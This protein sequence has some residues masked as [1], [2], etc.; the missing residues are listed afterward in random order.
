MARRYFGTDGIRG[1]VGQAP[2]TPDFVL[3]LGWAAG[4]VL[5][6]RYSGPKLILIGK[7]TR[8]S[9]YMFESAL[10]AGLINGGVDVG[11]LGPMPTPAIAYLTRTFQAQAGIVISAS[12]NPYHD[13]GIKFFSGQGTKLPDDIE[14]NIEAQLDQPMVTADNLGK[15]RRIN[16]AQGRYIEFCKGTMP[17]GFSLQGLKI[18]LDCANGA[19]YHVAP[20]VFRELGATVTTIGTQPDGMN[21]NDECGSTAPAALQAKVLETEADLGIAFDGDGDRVVFVDHKGEVVDGD[22]LLY[23]IASYR[24]EYGSGCNGVVGTL[25]SNLGFELALQS[26][27]IP[28]VRAKVGDRYVIEAM[29]NNDWLLGGESSGHIICSDVTTTGD[30]VISALQVLLALVSSGTALHDAKQGMRKTPQFT[31]NVRISQPV[32]LDNAPAIRSAVQET[33]AHLNGRGRVLL[34]PSGTEPLIR[35]MV[36]GE[37]GP[38]VQQLANQLAGV[39]QQ[40]VA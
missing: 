34:R 27:N 8:I 11:L 28:F 26:M 21:I 20:D 17:W 22:E 3:R 2:I 19:T 39:V 24:H 23:I 18:V 16:D 36:E 25:M 10:Q 6:E 37:D 9:G 15:A 30:G 4:R 5:A 1:R 14:Q 38:L 40:T 7:D 13:N 12:H 29:R 35:V 31:V 32:D 33:E